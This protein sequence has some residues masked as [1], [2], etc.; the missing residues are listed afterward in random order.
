MLVFPDVLNMMVNLPLRQKGKLIY[1]IINSFIMIVFLVKDLVSWFLRML[2]L[3]MKAWLMTYMYHVEWLMFI[4]FFYNY[5]SSLDVNKLNGP[6]AISPP[7]ILKECATELAPA[8]I[9]QLF[10]FSLVHG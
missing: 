9:S 8:S 2:H 4:K 10:N 1:L 6:N 3:S 5:I 7:R